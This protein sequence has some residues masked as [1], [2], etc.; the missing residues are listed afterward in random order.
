MTPEQA[1]RL[2]ALQDRLLEQTLTDADPLNWPGQGQLLSAMDK[3]TRGNAMWSRKTAVQTVALYCKV[4]QLA[5]DPAGACGKNKPTE[6][7]V[8][9]EIARAERAAADLLDRVGQATKVTDGHARAP[10]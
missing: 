5:T 2:Q 9:K 4:A 7:D 6:P 8:D 1:E 3:E 10:R